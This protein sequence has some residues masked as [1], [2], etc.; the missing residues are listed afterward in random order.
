M[1]KLAYIL[2]LLIVT[3]TSEPGTQLLKLP[4]LFGHFQTHLADGR[5]DDL[6]DFLQEHYSGYHHNDEDSEQDNRLPF[7]TSNADSFTGL[8]IPS[9]VSST[10]EKR[11]ITGDEYPVGRTD[12]TLQDCMTGV[13]HPPKIA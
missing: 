7:K 13:F 2:F 11:N 12:F 1:S 8:Y 3:L 4:M 5:S 6:L 10:C 9:I